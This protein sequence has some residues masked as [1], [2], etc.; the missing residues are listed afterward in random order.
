M[1]Y[2]LILVALALK[3]PKFIIIRLNWLLTDAQN[4]SNIIQILDYCDSCV[5]LDNPHTCCDADQVDTLNTNM[6][7]PREVNYRIIL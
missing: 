7:I 2:I 1:Y 5:C 6:K 3:S 4:L